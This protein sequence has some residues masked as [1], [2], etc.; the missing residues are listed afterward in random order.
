MFIRLISMEEKIREL[1]NERR[2]LK[3]KRENLEESY[4]AKSDFDK[5]VMAI[6]KA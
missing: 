6:R 1:E 4:K 2:K 3:A 5:K